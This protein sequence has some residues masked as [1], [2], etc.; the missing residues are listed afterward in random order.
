MQEISRNPDTLSITAAGKM[1]TPSWIETGQRTLG[2]LDFVKFYGDMLDSSEYNGNKSMASN[3]LLRIHAFAR[4]VFKNE[5]QGKNI[6]V[7]GHSLYFRTFFRF[8]MARKSKHIAKAKKIK[9]GGCVALELLRMQLP[10]GNE[11]Y[12]IT[13]ESVSVVYGGFE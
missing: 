9:N 10:N 6:I 5:H 13:D 2:G 1:P 7:G 11:T 4:W 8:F 3:G 12:Y